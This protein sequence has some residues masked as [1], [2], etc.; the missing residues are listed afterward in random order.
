M[1]VSY[2]WIIS[3]METIPQTE[4]L[5]DVVCCVNWRRSATTIV[6]EKEY[7]T[8][9]YGAMACQTPSA[10]DFTAYPDLTYEQVCSWLDSGIDTTEL[11]LNLDKQLEN[12]I[13]PPVV[14]LPL[15]WQTTTN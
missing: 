5:L 3:S 12:L 8:D 9:V 2:K 7:Y 11:D 1:N 14:T 6:D 13:N 10:T 4:G 15:P